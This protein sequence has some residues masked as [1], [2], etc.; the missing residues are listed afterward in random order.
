MEHCTLATINEKGNPE[1]IRNTAYFNLEDLEW[2][3]E[4]HQL[5]NNICMALMIIGMMLK[6]TKVN[7]P[8]KG[9]IH[10]VFWLNTIL[11]IPKVF[12]YTNR[13]GI[14]YIAYI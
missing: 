6:V 8:K 4:F 1:L 2:S 9:V 11:S 5:Q 7:I 13:Y 14:D 10:M 12:E 3:R